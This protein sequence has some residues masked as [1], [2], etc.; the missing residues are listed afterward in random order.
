MTTATVLAPLRRRTL[1][2]KIASVAAIAFLLL[3]VVAA[4][5]PQLLTPYDPLE[6]VLARALQPPSP[7]HPFGTDQTGRD[8]L[9]RIVYGA[10]Y[11]LGVGL[12]AAVGAAAIGTLIGALLGLA[13]R[14]LDAVFMR[15][16]EILMAFPD[17]LTALVV[18]AVLGAGPVNVAIAVLIGAIPAYIRVARAEMLTVRQTD[19]VQA[20]TLLGRHPLYVLR[21]HILP[22]TLRPILV[23]TTI[24]IGT[25]IVAA[26]GLSFLGL[27]A[28]EPDPDWGLM[29]SSARN[30]LSR[31]WWLAVFPGLAIILTVLS[32]SVVSRGFE[33][34]LYRLPKPGT[35]IDRGG[36]PAER[37]VNGKASS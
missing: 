4:L 33:A 3:L 10:R 29:L 25:S 14:W 32:V 34:G 2:S 28:Q 22:A 26:A 30:S 9:S 17:F 16:V 18:L 13:P 31:A 20:A 19:Y 6:N 8:V 23:L 12:A 7:A 15:A 24:G 36:R 37:L 1:G 27:G 5:W 21:R 35:A 11:S